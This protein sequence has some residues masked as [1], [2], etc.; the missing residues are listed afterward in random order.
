MEG[1][2]RNN[3]GV[4]RAL[5]ISCENSQNCNSSNLDTAMIGECWIPHTYKNNPHPRAKEKH[6]KTAGGAKCTFRVKPQT[7]Q[8][9]LEPNQKSPVHTQQA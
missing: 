7:H 6:N 4:E 5:I 3:G 2:S 8:R 9:Q 1:R